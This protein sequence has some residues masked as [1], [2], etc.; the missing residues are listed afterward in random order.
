[1]KEMW[2]FGQLNTLGEGRVQ[3]QTEKDATIVSELLDKLLEKK[4][5]TIE[6]NSRTG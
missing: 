1:M 6:G 3:E 2:L 5:A 4:Y